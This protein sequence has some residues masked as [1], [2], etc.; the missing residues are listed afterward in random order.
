MRLAVM[1]P[2]LFPYIGYFQLM[3]A[4]DLF[5]AY[6]DVAFIKQG[7]IARNR[8]NIRGEAALFSVPIQGASSFRLIRDTRV[9]PR[10][11]PG[12]RENFFKT[13]QANYARAP[14]RDSVLPLLEAVFGPGPE[15]IA[16]LALASLLAVRDMLGLACRVERS[17][18]LY[19][20]SRLGGQ[21]RILDIC[22]LSGATVYI[23]A[24]GGAALYDRETFRRNGVELFFLESA[25]V[26]YDQHLGLPFV[27][28]LSI[29][30]VLMHNPV[31]R[32]REFLDQHS[33]H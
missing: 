12:W 25:T 7:W 8:L 5:V 9:C 16:D 15:G 26:V 27:P 6:D 23:N 33:L 28:N 3:R 19:D 21:E 17:S 10:Q 32:V 18:A 31:E 4:A 1:Q 2:Y 29:I 11:Y 30:D 24:P 13:I 14:Y 20:N 22:R